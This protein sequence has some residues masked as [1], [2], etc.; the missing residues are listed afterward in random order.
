M[1]SGKTRPRSD[2]DFV[3]LSSLVFFRINAKY[4]LKGNETIVFMQR[5]SRARPRPLARVVVVRKESQRKR[6]QT[7][8]RGGK[9]KEEEE[10]S[11]RGFS[12]QIFRSFSLSFFYFFEKRGKGERE[13]CVVF[14]L[15]FLG[16]RQSK[17][18][19]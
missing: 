12:H 11:V 19:R 17:R 1:E 16:V 15:R 8:T 14:A 18:R 5:F 2:D 9:K 6:A 10:D 4:F 13:V 3:S 7:L